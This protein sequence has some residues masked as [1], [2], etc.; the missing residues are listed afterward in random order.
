MSGITVHSCCKINLFLQVT[1]RRADGYHTLQTL[2]LPVK[3]VGDTI[4]CDFNSAPGIEVI[5][6]QPEI[7]S[8]RSNLIYRAAEL[9]AEKS[10]IS[11]AWKFVLDKQIPVAAGLG[12]GSSNA[13]AVLS[14]LNAHYC[15]LDKMQLLRLAASVGADV[16]FFLES[17]PAWGSGIGDELEYLSQSHAPLYTVLVNPGF[18]VGVRWSYGQLDASKFAAADEKCKVE[19]TCALAENDIEKIALLCRNDLGNA[20]FL[21]FPQLA[22]LRK[23]M[24]DA[25]AACVQISGSGPTLFAVCG[26]MEIRSAVARKVREEFRSCSGVRVFEC[27]V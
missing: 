5:A 7:P 11:P 25:G 22:L 20:L 23:T 8:G 15:A 26:S 14:S 1:G 10:G 3:G 4:E 13:A 24:L 21:K 16:P 19:L 27:E 17:V 2:F 6:I 12:G 18:P 9:Y